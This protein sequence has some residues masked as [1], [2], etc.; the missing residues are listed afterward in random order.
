M[1]EYSGSF[2]ARQ[3]NDRVNALEMQSRSYCMRPFVLGQNIVLFQPETLSN[4]Y[5]VATNLIYRFRYRQSVSQTP[6]LETHVL[7]YAS[8]NRS[9]TV[10]FRTVPPL[11]SLSIR[12]KKRWSPRGCGTPSPRVVL[13]LET[14]SK[15]PASSLQVCILISALPPHQRSLRA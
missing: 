1:Y 2:D 13:G 3:S 10:A 11:S 15:P 4:S 12:Y 9:V 7:R 6:D 5:I 14:P 8:S